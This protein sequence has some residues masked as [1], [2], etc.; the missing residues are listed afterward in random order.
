VFFFEHSVNIPPTLTASLPYH[1]KYKFSKVAIIT[2]NI[3]AKTYLMTQLFNLK[4]NYV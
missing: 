3:Y 2:V 4:S 1:V